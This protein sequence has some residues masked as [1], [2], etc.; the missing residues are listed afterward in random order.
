MGLQK[1]SEKQISRKHL[2]LLEEDFNITTEVK[3]QH[4][5]GKKKGEGDKVRLASIH[6]DKSGSYSLFQI[7]ST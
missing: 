4:F 2:R 1:I 5:S 6:L 7:P 3:G